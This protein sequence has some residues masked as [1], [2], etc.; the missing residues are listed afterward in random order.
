MDVDKAIAAVE[1][2]L[3]QFIAFIVSFIRKD[4]ETEEDALYADLNA[5]VIFSIMGAFLGAYM[6]KRYIQF[7]S[8]KEA[9]SGLIEIA[10]DSLLRWISLGLALFFVLFLFRIK[11]HVV[12]SVIALLKAYVVSHVLSVYVGYIVKSLFWIFVDERNFTD[13]YA[14]FLAALTA[15]GLNVILV[16]I[17]VPREIGKL[18]PDSATVAVR[19]SSI[20]VYM[21]II[22]IYFA[23]NFVDKYYELLKL[24][25]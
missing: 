7:E 2:Y 19:V 3:R 10:A 12:T 18:M 4:T 8:H 6:W 20:I 1:R 14:A 9:A 17:F 25:F 5:T 24:H 11:S 21:S 23:L 16:T 13:D 15:W 22:Y